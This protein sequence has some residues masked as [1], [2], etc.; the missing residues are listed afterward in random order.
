MPYRFERLPL[1]VDKVPVET[2]GERVVDAVQ[3][4]VEIR[5]AGQGQQL[6][7]LLEER[8]LAVR[9][10]VLHERCLEGLRLAAVEVADFHTSETQVPL[11]ELTDSDLNV[12]LVL[13]VALDLQ[14]EILD[15]QGRRIQR[16]H[17]FNTAPDL[18]DAARLGAL[19]DIPAESWQSLA[20]YRA[21]FESLADPEVGVVLV[22]VM[23]GYG[24][25]PDPAGV[26]VEALAAAGDDPPVV[27]ASVCGTE[28]DPQPR[29][30]Q[31]ARLMAA[32]VLVAACNADAAELALQMVAGGRSA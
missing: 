9:V 21:W 18:E 11:V 7:P 1:Y 26:L 23:L 13:L 27:I 24:A 4:I 16:R 3:Q 2:D 32:G 17:W 28:R 15:E 29:S 8:K 10:D 20:E 6:R 22:D 12:V 30:Q 19:L 14:I 31:V 25:H 5:I